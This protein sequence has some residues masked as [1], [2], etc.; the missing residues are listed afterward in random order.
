M[1][2]RCVNCG[3]LLQYDIEK[4]QLLC[5]SCDSLFDPEGYSYE[6]DAKE[7]SA[8]M[9]MRLFSCPNCGGEI[10]STSDEAVEYC[11]YCGSFV[12]LDSQ[13]ANVKRPDYIMPFSKTKDE[14]KLSYKRMMLR[15]LYA[16][17]EFRDESFLEGFK[18]IYIPYWTYDYEFGPDVKIK[19]HTE[20]RHGDYIYKQYYNTTCKVDGRMYGINYDASSSFDDDISSRVL[21]FE[22]SK[23]KKFNSS[24]MFG[25]FGDTADVDKS[26]YAADAAEVARDE[27]WNKVSKD[28]K[29][30]KGSPDKTT[31]KEFDNDFNMRYRA[32]MSMLPVW[33]LTWRKK[34]R[35]AYSVVNGDTGEIYSEI[36]VDTKRYL[37]ISLI[38]AIPLY[39]ILDAFFTFNASKM[40][41]ISLI[42]SLVMIILYNAQ[43]EKIVRRIL[44]ADDKGYINKH[45]EAKNGAS[46]VTRN[47]LASAG[48]AVVELLSGTGSSGFVTVLVILV[49]AMLFMTAYMIIGTILV[50]LLIVIYTIY[51]IGKCSKLLHDRTVWTDVI[52]SFVA[53]AIS[54]LM[55]IVDPA[56]D[57]F[58]YVA[59]I[60]SIGLVAL[61]AVLTMRRY[62]ELVT[63][64][65]PHFFDRKEGGVE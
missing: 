36:P 59:A 44:H 37:L 22:R 63:R 52:W 34:D 15:K 57:M 50:S 33:F 5:E 3:G 28:P 17:K 4:G 40:L 54:M 13:L 65:L 56:G 51:R 7:N 46:K 27:I 62:N 16:P 39:F 48:S 19:G 49:S 43:V 26:V 58:Y 10:S 29:V 31:G 32:S 60:I 20:T 21:P 1:L 41:T 53:L 8:D 23:L 42:M 18:G 14:C 61:T 47:F 30:A 45:K 11:L 24:Y 55:L 12:T 25:F 6:T 35:V 9:Q 2:N 38:T 64:P